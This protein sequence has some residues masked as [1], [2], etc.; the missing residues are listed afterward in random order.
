VNFC[1]YTA[2]LI[3][4]LTFA[5]M[6]PADQAIPLR[7]RGEIVSHTSDSLL[8]HRQSGDTVT[9]DILPDIPIS[10]LRRIALADI[11]PHS[12]IGTAARVDPQGRQIAQVVLV[13]PESAR[14]TGEGHHAWDL[15][16]QSSMINANVDAITRNSGGIDLLLSHKDGADT[17]TVPANVP[18][19]TFVPA[20]VA[21]LT[22]GRKVFAVVAMDGTNHYLAQRIVVEKNGVVPPM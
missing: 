6:A 22:A 21:D 4:G 8:I 5:T 10:S 13:F 2:V 17:I 3:A 16:P 19:E 11:K 15:G 14:G 12:Y 1:I 9:V 18:V 7:I 20:D